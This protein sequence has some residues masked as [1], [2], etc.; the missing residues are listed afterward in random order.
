M[1]FA[2]SF[3]AEKIITA[4]YHKRN[5]PIRSQDVSEL[6]D[7]IESVI[8]ELDLTYFKFVDATF[9]IVQNLLLSFKRIKSYYY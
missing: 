5:N 8:E 7:E 3:C 4:K 2:C 1:P 6:C 9:D